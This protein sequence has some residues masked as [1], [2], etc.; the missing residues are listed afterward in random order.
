MDR[1]LTVVMFAGAMMAPLRLAHA[2]TRAMPDRQ[3]DL[4]SAT[5]TGDFSALP[6][7]P[8]GKSTILGGEIRNVDPVLDQFTLRTVG[9][10]PMKILFDERTQ[11]FKNGNKIPLRELHS[12]EHASVQTVLEGANVF[13][14][15]IHMLSDLPEGECQGRVLSYDPGT[16]ELTI[17]SSLSRE[18]IRLLLR[19]ETQ[20]V[21]VG[22]TA[23][24]SA[25]AGKT[26][27]V[28]GALVNAKFDANGKGRAVASHVTVL[29]KPG[30]EFA[31]SGKLSSLDLHS[32]LLVLIDLRDQKSYQ[33]SFTSVTVPASDT[34][35]AGDQVRV[36]ATY[37]G[38]S[39]TATQIIPLQAPQP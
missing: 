32:G 1:F 18:P 9:Q 11:V 30:S 28:N 29:A 24:V 6:A 8:H 12:D 3:A 14:I 20:V 21:R 5:A 25:S 4:E 15:S 17:G 10:R 39:Y 16:H 7:M 33:I 37:D 38:A 26:D 34:L 35:H 13:A 19:D 36:T 27:L 22:Q 2:Q 23:F 31:F